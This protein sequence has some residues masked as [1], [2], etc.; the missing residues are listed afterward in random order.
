MP[1]DEIDTTTTPAAVTPPAGGGASTPPATTT[2][3]TTP[4]PATTTPPAAPRELP[5][6]EEPKPGEK[7]TLTSKQLADRIDRA[8][9]Q[10]VSVK[11]K[12]LVGTDDA[13][14]IKDNET[15]RKQLEAD[16]EKARLAGL[17]EI[18]RAKEEARIAKGRATAAEERVQEIEENQAIAQA[19]E[20]VKVVALDFIAPKHWRHVKNDLS[21]HLANKFTVEQLDAMSE[22]DSEKEVRDYLAEY[23]KENP[24]FAKKD[25]GTTTTTTPAKVPLTNGAGNQ[26]DKPDPSLAGTKWAG[27]TLKPGL[28]NS[29][30]AAEVRD[31]KKANGYTS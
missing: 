24:E 22:K 14:V 31:W 17:G 11:L 3:A 2:P 26:G 6:G 28:A 12:E 18:E 1:P 13:Q 29:M 7:I 8:S 16:A 19:G 20:E 15:K 5:D 21:T 30:T 4:A 27:K 25:G 23:V 9:K 10:A